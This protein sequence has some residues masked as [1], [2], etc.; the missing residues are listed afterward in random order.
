V[1]INCISGRVGIVVIYI[2]IDYAR[3]IGRTEP[4]KLGY[5]MKIK[6]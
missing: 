6:K 2:E 4:Q 5:Y 3:I 1:V